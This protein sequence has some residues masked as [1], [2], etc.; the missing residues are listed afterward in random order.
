VLHALEKIQGNAL[1]SRLAL[2][3]LSAPALLLHWALTQTTG[4]QQGWVLRGGAQALQ[5]PH[6]SFCH[7]A[8]AER[9]WLNG[10]GVTFI[11][12]QLKAVGF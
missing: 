4:V 10:L 3:F 6:K 1:R 5:A 2:D 11:S 8:G 9:G 12:L 7:L